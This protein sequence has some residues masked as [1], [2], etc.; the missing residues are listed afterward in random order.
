[1]NVNDPL[2]VTMEVSQQPT[3]D[4]TQPGAAPGSGGTG[5]TRA[6][7]PACDG[8]PSA[9]APGSRGARR[10]IS[11]ADVWTLARCLAQGRLNPPPSRWLGLLLSLLT[12]VSA[13][14]ADA[15]VQ[16]EL[17]NISVTGGLTD[18]K[19][20]LV[21]EADL[22][23]VGGE[24]V[25][26]IFATQV[27][28]SMQAGLDLL[29]HTVRLNLEVL[30][31]QPKE[32]AFNLTGEGRVLNVTG[33]QLQDWSLREQAGGGRQLVVRSKAVQPV[34]TNF[35]FTVTAETALTNLPATLTPL[36]FA[37]TQ[38][39][40]THGFIVLE[41]A[42]GV[43]LE[44]A[45]PTGA[46]PV[47][48]RF[49]PEN[50][51]PKT[52]TSDTLA[53][54]FQGAAYAL[55]LTLSPAD[56]EA[57]RV[58]LRDFKLTGRFEADR[59]SF[60]L[61]AT[62]RVKHPEG[63]RLELL[64]GG[65]ALTGFT[66][67]P[68][69][70]IRLEGGR[71]VLVCDQPGEFPIEVQ[72]D[73]SVRR[74]NEWNAIQF[75]VAPST[76]QPIVL[77]GL[78]ADTE[79]EF[80]GAARPERKGNDFTSFLPADGSVNLAWKIA[81]AEETGKLFYAT[82]MFSQISVGSG[83][84]RQTAIIEG[85]VMQGELTRVVLLLQGEDEI[86][87]VQGEGVLSWKAEPLAA[88]G[89]RRL[90]VEFNQ[91]QREH[92]SLLVNVQ[93]PLGAFPLAFSALQIRP[94][95]ATRFAGWFRIVNEGAVRLEVTGASGLSQISPEQF[96]ETEST[97]NFLRV[98][99]NQRFAYRFSGADFALRIQADNILPELAVS[100]LL[101]YHLGETDLAID[102]EL[103]L[104]IRE[105]P[106][107]EV[108]LRVPR[109][110]ALARLTASGLSDSFLQDDP[111]GPDAELRLVYG[112]PILGRQ[113]IQVRLERNESLRAESWALPRLEVLKAKST[114]GN[115]GISADAGFRLTPETT[116][117]LTEIGNAFFPKKLAG[118]QAA[119]RLSDPAWRATLRIERLPQS[120][121]ADVFHLFS[122]GEGIAYGSSTMN[123]FV[124]GAP[125]AGFRV[126]LSEEYF[127]VE[128]AGKDIRNWQKTTNGYVVQLHT[129]VA[130]AYTLLA[131][132][133]RPFKAQGATLTFT[134]ARPLDAQNEQ[135]LT[136]VVSAYQFQVTPAN[137]SPGLLRLETTE[138]PPETRLFF[139]AP[140]LAAYR[141]NARPFNLQLQL[142]PLTQGETVSL[143]VDRATLK[144]RI[145][146]EGQV[147]TDA[148]Y[149]VKNRGNPNL[150]LTLPEGV[151]LWDV[152]VN[153]AAVTPVAD[154]KSNLIPLPPRAD[155]NAVL[156]L[157]LKLAS[158]SANPKRVPVAAPIVAAPV[159][160]AEWRLE[161][162]TGQ[163]LVYRHGTL[164]PAGGVNDVSGF[165]GLARMLTLG[166]GGRVTAIVAV[167]LILIGLAAWAWRWGGGEGSWRYGPRHTVGVALGVV[168]FLGFT[169]LCFNLVTLAGEWR[170]HPT[171]DLTMVAPV[172]QAQ[173]AW[174]VEVDNVKATA[175]VIA[176][177]FSL[178]LAMAAVVAWL[179]A[180]VTGRV[181]LRAVAWTLLA[182]AVLRYTN[183]APAF[184]ALLWL[185]FVVQVA[186]PALRQAFRAPPRPPAAAGPTDESSGTSAAVATAALLLLLATS[187][188]QAAEG[189]TPARLQRETPIAETVFQQVRLEE[190]Y[191]F[192]TVKLRWHALAGQLLPVLREPAVLTAIQYPT[193]ALKLVD[194]PSGGTRTYALL[195]L[196]AGTFEVELRYQIQLRKLGEE[197]GFTLR[198][199][200]GLVNEIT[201]TI[202]GRDV[203]IAQRHAVSV[204]RRVE[205]SNTVA[206][207][208]YAPSAEAW[209]GWK[210]RSRDVRTERAVFFAEVQNLYVP[211]A[212]IIE[213][214]HY[215]LIRPAQG[216]L[217]ELVLEVPGG[218]T[219]TDV[220][221]PAST[222][223]AEGK[224]PPPSRVAFWRFDPDARKL[225]LSLSPAQSR[226]FGLLVK[227]QVATGP[228]PFAKQV[229]LLGVSGASG[230]IGLLG[231]ATGAEV[232]L[233]TVEA[234]GITAINLE[235]YPA[236]LTQTLAAQFPGLALR[237]AF[238]YTAPDATALLKASAVEP[239]VRVTTQ[240]TLS[241]GE[242]RTVLGVNAAVEVTRAGIFR[243]SFLLPSGLEV[244]TVNGEAMSH[245]TELKTDAGRVITLHLK[246]KT[247]G[248]QNFAL[249]LAGPGLKRATNWAVPQFKFREATKQQGQLVV[250]PEQG[251][252]LQMAAMEGTTQ[253]D[254][255]KAGI[256]Q[257]GVL[258]FRLLQNVWRVTL[259]LEQVDAWVQVTSLQNFSLAD[260]QVKVA[261][262]L[263]YQIENTGL[264]SFRVLVPTN[265]ENVFFNGEQV[266]D[267]LP[268]TNSVTDG[269]QAWEIKLARRVIG[270]Y[271]LQVTYQLRL[272][273]QAVK[274]ELRGVRADEV[275]LQRGFV[276]LQSGG[277]LQVRVD[278]TPAALQPAEWQSIPR[279][280]QQDIPATSASY[281]YRLVEPAYTLPVSFERRDAARLLPAQVKNLT[282]T[283]AVS[284]EGV[285]LTQV[286][287]EMLPGDKRL[288]RLTLP[289]GATFWFAF[290]NQN[291]VWPWLE[292]DQILIPLEQQLRSDQPYAVEFFYSSQIGRPD[293]RALDLQ[294]L[295]PKFD[296][297]L[298]NLTWRVFLNEKWTLKDWSGTLQLSESAAARMPVTL[299]V[300]GYL[301]GEA[302]RQQQ[303]TKVAEQWLNTGNQMLQQGNPEQAR[304]AFNN[305]FGL[306]QHDNAFNEDARVQLHNLKM[307][308]ALLGLNVRQG[309]VGPEG[310]AAAKLRDLRNRKDANYTQEEAKQ[311]IEANPSDDNA[312]LMRLAERLVQQQDAAVANPAVIRAT[313]PEQGRLL[314][315]KRSV[316]VD[317][318]ADMQLNLATRAAHTVG[319]WGRVLILGGCFVLLAV[320]A[321]ASRRRTA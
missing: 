73:A 179:A 37:S 256:R 31:G 145:S 165:A 298:E 112:S 77:Q 26:P 274:A 99:G 102:A 301:Q 20:R 210:P 314:T 174:T 34:A 303:Q 252:R 206:R 55:P 129:P 90:V 150:K 172:Q 220:T 216:E 3:T 52:P 293:A 48:P 69:A 85:K 273:D 14:A 121:Q 282:L 157:D 211:S 304:F 43:Q 233:D 111:N 71:F 208:V 223:A 86:T 18:D 100:Q 300:S 287:L 234:Q 270:R 118:I 147:L 254:P 113:V 178:V 229:G 125:I 58:V 62:A 318:M 227:S 271:L 108:V 308:Q 278:A 141:Y 12:V 188:I 23:G 92:F 16:A 126:E 181:L 13:I 164:T 294:L 163:R 194:T 25:A 117:G 11:K 153:G 219:I 63:A 231:V 156:T 133:E 80:A 61:S 96:P 214:L 184:F 132:Y 269:L 241:L 103:E 310:G 91:P 321:F 66:T 205:G 253:L 38:P 144:T 245:W 161:P 154:G 195:A 139:D 261:A 203:D 283:S 54:R 235:D 247:E 267:S 175:A 84:M 138:V 297:P 137:V 120:V 312:A 47:E 199:Q 30:Q 290:V 50:L 296:L 7:R 128:F 280:L 2:R 32:F 57:R 191:A 5:H 196:E 228:L 67:G 135:G 246:G 207:L 155:P 105:A 124:S 275:N 286:R 289:K 193:N 51:R 185:F 242:D 106:V 44:V 221:D 95:D 276:T 140:I 110:Y 309:G 292:Q 87:R 22:K 317:Q 82:E 130:G 315:F 75:R 279:A 166:Q 313:I 263:Q 42:P 218:V 88:A 15:P 176:P 143:V 45:N 302:T 60:V 307:Q 305:A 72:F 204:E 131:T 29:T 41:P 248:Q 215:V 56:P 148:R 152:K 288:L 136:I 6:Q 186:W 81:R 4:H 104:D 142:S 244:E 197:T 40:L 65:A 28:Q 162:D 239:D 33:D 213:G 265:A 180:L 8:R 53:F 320:V 101:A 149:F 198:T 68:N 123:F 122:I 119:F 268:L 35:S 281:T 70:R 202:V 272:A 182:W 225:R 83:L 183:S 59:A 264:K 212:G 39:A 115:V 97:K 230:Q 169:F 94:E 19:A 134:G 109:G 158:R 173:S 284:D 177:F 285:M 250:V 266:A 236:A 76:L 79:F 151:S 170:Q 187:S 255:Q 243:L 9:A 226:P 98:T 209:L 146:Q 222:V 240:E 257:K 116:H 224:A 232:Q 200:P 217:A 127:N 49:L 237:R 291:G 159:L 192:A 24:R 17:K 160:L 27:H 277:R 78:A 114:R 316:Q 74:S 190:E 46:V 258:A 201:A 238:R 107:R 189:G 168:A 319:F 262:N 21:I 311:I 36:A 64:T 10:S 89:G 299:D 171:A 259:D 260:A 249:T 295:G 306:S 1:M 251:M 167:A 93:R